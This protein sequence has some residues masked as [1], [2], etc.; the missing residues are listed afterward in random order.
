[1]SEFND[2]LLLL[3]LSSGITAALTALGLMKR[4]GSMFAGMTAGANMQR[5]HALDC[6][7]H[8]CFSWR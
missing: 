7:L 4:Q 1:M 2:H 8:T 5:K 6:N 3:T